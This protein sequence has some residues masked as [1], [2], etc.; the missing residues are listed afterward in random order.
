[1]LDVTHLLIQEGRG[2]DRGCSGFPLPAAI[3]SVFDCS[4]VTSS[5]AGR[6]LGVSIAVF[7]LAFYVAMGVL[8]ILGRHA[9]A[10]IA[11]RARTLRLVAASVAVVYAV[12]LVY[13]QH[14]VLREYCALCLVS[15]AVVTSPVSVPVG[16]STPTTVY[17]SSWRASASY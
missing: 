1:M 9:S 16:S 11:R 13:Y 7:G 15:A 5:S 14:F 10:V 6:V 4:I 8:T 2:F 12:Y 3:E 17:S